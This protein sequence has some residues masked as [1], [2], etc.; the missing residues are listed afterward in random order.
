M[1]SFTVLNSLKLTFDELSF[2]QQML[3][4]ENL[5]QLK[6]GM[7]HEQ[8]LSES[9]KQAADAKFLGKILK[10]I[11]KKYQ[12]AKIEKTTAKEMNKG[13]IDVY[14]KELEQLSRGMR[15]F[16]TEVIFTFGKLEI[17]YASKKDFNLDYREGIDQFNKI[18]TEFS[19]IPDEWSKETASKKEQE[20]YRNAEKKYELAKKDILNLSR[21]EWRKRSGFVY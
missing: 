1:P 17:Q 14:K 7:I 10:G 15:E 9:K 6:L 18:A 3:V 19:K 21:R 13:G 16:G 4:L 12:I 2:G 11:S 8:G 5:K 20:K